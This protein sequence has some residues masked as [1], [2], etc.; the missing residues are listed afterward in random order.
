VA[1]LR[2]APRLSWGWAARGAPAAPAGPAAA[3]TAATA[4]LCCA[5]E[6]DTYSAYI[7]PKGS[8][9]HKLQGWALGSLGAGARG[10]L[11]PVVATLASCTLARM[12]C[13]CNAGSY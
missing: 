3:P 11:G 1:R 6:T 10:A 4:C 12:Q 9:A 5:G 2:G 7:P 13:S 8:L